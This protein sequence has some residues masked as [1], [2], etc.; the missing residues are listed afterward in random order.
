MFLFRINKYLYIKFEKARSHKYL[1]KKPDGHGGWIYIYHKTIA[2]KFKEDIKEFGQENTINIVKEIARTRNEP[3]EHGTFY[4]DK[5]EK[6]FYK[7]GTKKGILYTPDEL[8]ITYKAKLSIHNHPDGSNFSD[9]DFILLLDR[10][11]TEMRAFGIKDNKKTNF[12]I[13]KIKE[14][15][16]D[17]I[18]EIKNKYKKSVKS[19]QEKL[20]DSIFDREITVSQANIKFAKFNLDYFLQLTKGYY[21]YE[22]Y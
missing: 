15:S 10:D 21:K 13:K 4:N 2:D 18:T 1:E 6:F 16:Y 22:K 3:I 20:Q 12:S 5:G 9:Q 17:Q 8:R 14:I 19:N 11:I 7:K